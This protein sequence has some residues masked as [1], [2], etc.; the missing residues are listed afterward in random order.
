MRQEEGDGIMQASLTDTTTDHDGE[1][2][3]GV[4]LRYLAGTALLSFTG[5][6]LGGEVSHGFGLGLC[7]AS[8]Q[9]AAIALVCAALWAGSL[10]LDAHQA[11][12]RIAQLPRPPYSPHRRTLH[13]TTQ[14]GKYPVGPGAIKLIATPIDKTVAAYPGRRGEDKVFFLLRAAAWYR[15]ALI[16]LVAGVAILFVRSFG[17]C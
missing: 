5:L 10:W 3:G 1:L 6:T 16:V 17:A 8:G 15:T 11:A 12:G 4:L 14:A 2:G 9:L 7:L 13:G